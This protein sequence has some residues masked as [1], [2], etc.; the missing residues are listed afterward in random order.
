MSGGVV[1]GEGGG[2]LP[3][4]DSACSDGDGGAGVEGVG[5]GGVESGEGWTAVIGSES[6]GV[7]RQA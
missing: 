6:I 5:V 7:V 3:A 2:G 1:G 4:G